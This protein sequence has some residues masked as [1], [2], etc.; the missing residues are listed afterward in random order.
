MIADHVLTVGH[1]PQDFKAQKMI[2]LNTEQVSHQKQLTENIAQIKQL[3]AYV[4]YNQIVAE[5]SAGP[6]QK[7][8]EEALELVADL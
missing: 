3:A 2:I 4:Q 7:V 8:A 5:A 1:S 6:K